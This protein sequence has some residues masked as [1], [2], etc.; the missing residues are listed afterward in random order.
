MSAVARQRATAT[1]VSGE[2]SSYVYDGRILVGF[3]FDRSKGCIATLDD[4][5]SLGQFPNWKEARAAISEEERRR[6]S[7]SPT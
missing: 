5:R 4:R 7:E 2:P 1:T 6:G 3:I